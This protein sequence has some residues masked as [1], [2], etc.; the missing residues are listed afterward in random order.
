MECRH[1][2]FLPA[3]Q[4]HIFIHMQPSSTRQAGWARTREA[5]GYALALGKIDLHTIL[6]IDYQFPER[7]EMKNECQIRIQS[8]FKISIF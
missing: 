6:H 2:P 1:K 7:N 5:R 3:N 4:A 8:T